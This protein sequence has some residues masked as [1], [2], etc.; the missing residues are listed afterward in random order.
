MT[1]LVP[2]TDDWL[3]TKNGCV[4]AEIMLLID[5][6][7]RVCFWGNDDFGMEQDFNSKETAEN[8]FELTTNVQNITIKELDNLGFHSS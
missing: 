2:T 3:P 7:W 8:M 5:G 1:K 6:K 4:K